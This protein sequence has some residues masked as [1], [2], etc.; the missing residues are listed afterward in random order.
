M[1]LIGRGLPQFVAHV[2]GV[3]RNSPCN[4]TKASVMAIIPA[5]RSWLR[6]SL[7]QRWP[8]SEADSRARLGTV[9]IQSGIALPH[10]PAQLVLTGPIAT[11][12]AT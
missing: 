6:Q 2:G 4:A 8:A 11:G 12:A 10:A 1:V 9:N 5:M 3:S 7:R